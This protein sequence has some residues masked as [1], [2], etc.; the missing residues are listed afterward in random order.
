MTHV[1]VNPG[2]C[3][4]TA[5]IKAEMCGRKEAKLAI[6]TECKL[7]AQY[8]EGLGEDVDAFELLGMSRKGS[9]LEARRAGT[10]IH[11]ACPVIAGIAKALEAEAQLALPRDVSITFVKD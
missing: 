2:V 10:R 9:S 7:I 3:G 11:A 5:D 6:E 8:A 4:L 1:I